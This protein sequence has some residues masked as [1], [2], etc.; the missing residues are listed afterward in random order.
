MEASGPHLAL[1]SRS[2][3]KGPAPSHTHPGTAAGRPGP[4]PAR[5][6]LNTRAY[7]T[8]IFPLTP[9]TCACLLPD[10]RSP[11]KGVAC[12]CHFRCN[13]PR[14]VDQGPLQIYKPLCSIDIRPMCRG[15]EG[16]G[17]QKPTVPCG[18]WKGSQPQGE[19]LKHQLK[20]SGLCPGHPAFKEADSRLLL[21]LEPGTDLRPLFGSL[22]G[23]RTPTCQEQ[24]QVPSSCLVTQHTPQ[25]SCSL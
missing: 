4:F 19:G 9:P 6:C 5:L 1:F 22:L 14:Q 24:T 25:G 23:I 17:D 13:L 21:S 15:W 18:A 20:G 11:H 10:V 8:N 2:V 3:P 16:S 7:P 12:P